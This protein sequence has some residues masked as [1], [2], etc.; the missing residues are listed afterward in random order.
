MLWLVLLQHKNCKLETAVK[1]RMHGAES[2]R[3]SNASK[4]QHP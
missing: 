1:G 3:V 2:E 4:F